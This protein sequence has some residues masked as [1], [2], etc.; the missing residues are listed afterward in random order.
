MCGLKVKI[1]DIRNLLSEDVYYTFTELQ[2]SG[3]PGTKMSRREITELMDKKDELVGEGDLGFKDL[4][5]KSFNSRYVFWNTHLELIELFNEYRGLIES[6]EV[7]GDDM[8]EMRRARIYSEVKGS[9]NIEGYN[10]TRQLFDEL[11]RGREPMNKNEVV[12]RNMAHAIDYVQQGLP[13]NRDNFNAL[14]RII[15][16]DCLDEDQK[17]RDGEYYRYDDVFISTYT[18]APVDKIAE[19]MDSLFEMVNRVIKTG[20]EMLRFM[21]PHIVHYYIVYIHPFFDCNGRMARMCSLWISALV[22]TEGNPY[23][24]SEAIN[25]TKKEYYHAISR[26]RDARND[27]TYFLKYIMETSISY[28]LSYIKL[29][30][31]S[32][33]V[34]IEGDALTLTEQVYL[35]KLIIKLDGRYFSWHD[36]V[37]AIGSD[38]SKQAALKYLNKWL[39][40][41]LLDSKLNTRK[42]KVFKI[43]D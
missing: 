27:L 39:S 18:G 31:F 16:E 15:S 6:E 10:S 17:L 25:D 34:A 7:F 38:M 4:G 41:G 37:A 43:R 26:T 5:L 8:D 2:Y 23:F 35:K 9:I 40:Y 3:V 29:N 30:R 22:G 11:V 28:A 13:F 1:M 33:I 21:L 42:E 36:F 14:Y 24:I 19:C 32:E 20:D 12:V